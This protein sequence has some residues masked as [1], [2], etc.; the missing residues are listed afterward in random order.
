LA[1]PP[2][3]AVAFFIFLTAH[4]LS[5]LTDVHVPTDYIGCS[6]A[7]RC[8]HAQRRI[9]AVDCPLHH[10]GL[11]GL[12]CGTRTRIMIALIVLHCLSITDAVG[13]GEKNPSLFPPC[14]PPSLVRADRHVSIQFELFLYQTLLGA[15]RSKQSSFRLHVEG[16]P[17]PSHPGCYHRPYCP[18]K[19]ASGSCSRRPTMEKFYMIHRYD[20]RSTEG[21]PVPNKLSE[22]TS[23]SRY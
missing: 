6:A 2:A 8:Q 14:M 9:N 22:L 1:P 10:I 12:M 13:K 21:L 18:V 7:L 19:K 23:P 11:T 20:R 17:V 5:L 4:P 16:K 15:T 3:V